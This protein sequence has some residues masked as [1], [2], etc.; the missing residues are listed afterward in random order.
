[1]RFVKTFT[2]YGEPVEPKTP[3]K[4]WI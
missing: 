3:W 1:V 2:F 4:Y